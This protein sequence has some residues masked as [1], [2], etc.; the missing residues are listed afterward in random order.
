[1]VNTPKVN[2]LAPIFTANNLADGVSPYALY[3]TEVRR[4]GYK[5]YTLNR[6]EISAEQRIHTFAESVENS[7][8]AG[9]SAALLYQFRTPPQWQE[10]AD[11]YL[12]T[13]HNKRVRRRGIQQLRGKLTQLEIREHGGHYITT[14]E[15][16]FLDL[17]LTMSAR[18]LVYVA[19]GLL[20]APGRQRVSLTTMGSLREYLQQ[21]KNHRGKEACLEALDL[22]VEGVDSVKET[23]LRLLLGD[24]G[25]SSLAVNP[26]IRDSRGAYVCEPDL[27]DFSR[28]ISIQYEGIHHTDLRQ[29][30]LDEERRARTHAAGWIEVRIFA[31]DLYNLEYFHGEMMPKAVVKVLQAR[32]S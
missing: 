2:D 30:R 5:I 9:P 13:L 23:E 27:A 3:R 6:A 1:M 14:V 31:A 20:P 10:S 21:K 32:N 22:A 8:I 12:Y 26:V 18:Q 7:V 24:Y 19:D 17:G 4:L 25:I 15:R 29:M 11:I 28:K 16:T